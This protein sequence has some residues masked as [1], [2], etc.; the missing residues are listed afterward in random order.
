MNRKGSRGLTARESPREESG[1]SAG[2]DREVIL[3]GG[4]QPREERPFDDVNNVGVGERTR[5]ESGKRAARRDVAEARILGAA[6]P[7]GGKRQG[8]QHDPRGSGGDGGEKPLKGGSPWTIR[9]EIWL[10]DLR[11]ET[12]WAWKPQPVGMQPQ[13]CM[14]RPRERELVFVA[15]THRRS[16]PEEAAQAV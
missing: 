16:D 4:K 2:R 8:G 1:R 5:T 12:S 13:G 11:H 3:E 7:Q 15:G 14:R 10:A 9:P 6:A